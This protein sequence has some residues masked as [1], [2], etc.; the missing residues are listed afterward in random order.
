[1]RRIVMLLATAVLLAAPSLARAERIV[2]IEVVENTKTND[3]TVLLI[4]DVETGD[5]YYDGMMDRI[6]RDLENSGLFKDMNAFVA[7]SMKKAGLKLTIVA[8]DKHSWIIAPTVYL[9]PGNKGG[10]FGFAE[11]NLWGSNKKLLLYGQIATSDS[12]FL[13]GY[14]EPN[15][16]GSPIYFR[17]D[18]FLRRLEVTEYIELDTDDDIVG[19]PDPARYSTETYLNSGFMLGINVWKGMALD[20]R[21]RGAYVSF[22]DAYCAEHNGVLVDDAMYGCAHTPSDDGFDVS[23]EWKLTYDKR[24][25]WYGIVTGNLLGISYERSLPELG[26]EFDYWV[27]YVR[28]VHAVKFFDEHN[29]VMKGGVTYGKTLP[30]QQELTSG[31]TNLRGY[32]NMQ[33][34]GDTKVSGSL[35]YSVPFFKIGPVAFRGLGFVDTA[36][37]SFINDA[38]NDKRYYLATQTDNRPG[39]FRIGVGGGFRIY[40]RSIVMPL[41][42]VD[43]G[44]GPQSGERNIYFA[45]GLTEL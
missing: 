20:G 35:E 24:A 28:A 1:M 42:G 8:K 37:T 18:L 41:L 10:G 30:F 23:T 3:E 19:Q 12:L 29:L 31:G 27:T 36:Y 32:Q 45:V 33:F 44:Y 4:A 13:A 22:K 6:K 2:E 38:G 43:V 17:A 9:Q 26:S 11:N 25:N 39:L 40:V 14:L 5:E 15:L 16:F 34:R 7:P 21:L